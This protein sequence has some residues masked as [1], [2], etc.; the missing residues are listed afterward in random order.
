[1]IGKHCAY[2]SHETPMYEDQKATVAGWVQS[3]RGTVKRIKR[4]SLAIQK[5]NVETMVT[6]DLGGKQVT[7]TIYEWM[8][9][10]GAGKRKDGGLATLEAAGLSCLTD[11]GLRPI[12]VA[13]T[14]GREKEI[15]V[16][17]CF[18]PE[19]RDKELDLL[20][21]E[22]SIVDAQLEVVNATTD[23]VMEVD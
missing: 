17:L 3:Y 2:L 16:V 21:S 15:T 18:K 13:D 20:R 19:E 23:L 9:R 7:Q 4:L 12:H 6:I 10:R 11:R 1:M 14:Q 8:Q 22:P 5:T